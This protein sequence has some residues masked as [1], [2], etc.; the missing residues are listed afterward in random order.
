MAKASSKKLKDHNEKHGS[1]PSPKK[2]N[3]SLSSPIKDKS[4]ISDFNNK[5][6]GKDEELS[7]NS[8]RDLV[9]AFIESTFIQK[10]MILFVILDIFA[11]IVLLFI[12]GRVIPRSKEGIVYIFIV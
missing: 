12:E 8:W 6:E 7:R 3:N 5:N 2:L 1:S 11:A 4:N 9:G 10:L